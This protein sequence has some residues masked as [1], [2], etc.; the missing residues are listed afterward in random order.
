MLFRELVKNLIAK[1]ILT[2][3]TIDIWEGKLNW[4]PSKAFM[5]MTDR[6]NLIFNYTWKDFW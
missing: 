5:T 6:Y 4:K 1:N 2:E 3:K